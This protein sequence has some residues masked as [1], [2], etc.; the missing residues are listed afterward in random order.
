[1]SQPPRYR[2]LD[3]RQIV[4][5]IRKLRGR[6]D[7]RFPGSGLSNVTRELL[8][9]GEETAS[10]LRF[11]QRPLWSVRVLVILTIA[12]MVAVVAA[13]VVTLPLHSGVDGFADFMQALEAGINDVIFFGLAIFFLATLE[14]RVKRGRALRALHQLRSLAHIV[15]M[16][17]LT[18]DPEGI[19][20][21]HPDAAPSDEPALTPAELARYLDYCSELLSLT[22]KL[23]ALHVQHLNDPVVLGAV[24]E[25]ET[26]T[27]NLS[28]KIWQKITL[29]ERTEGR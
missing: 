14:N 5:T 9:V 10:L 19:M 2:Q 13:V 24:T 20:S 18:K 28:S 6:V 4:D 8:T 29:L 7:A 26:V 25:I 21:P 23:A 1:M 16:H 12:V 11:L 22:A 17:Q 27:S 15:D 3:E